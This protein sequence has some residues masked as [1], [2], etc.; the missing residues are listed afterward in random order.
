MF[1]LSLFLVFLISNV[2]SESDW[3]C[4][5]SD[6]VMAFKKKTLLN[7]YPNFKND[8]YLNQ[9]KSSLELIKQTLL[10]QDLVCAIKYET[11]DRTEYTIR[12]FKDAATALANEHIITHQGLSFDMIKKGRIQF[13]GNFNFWKD[14]AA[15]VRI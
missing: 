6:A 8:P 2:Q 1:L 5:K 12:N 7:Q 9:T 13:K 11:S 15:P 14:L 10:D 4:S 3:N